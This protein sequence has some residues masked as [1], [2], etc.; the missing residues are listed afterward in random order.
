M[1]T[2]LHITAYDLNLLGLLSLIF[3]SKDKKNVI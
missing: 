2:F 3:D 1:T